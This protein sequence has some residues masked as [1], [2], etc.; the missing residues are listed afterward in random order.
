MYRPRAPRYTLLTLCLS[1][2]LAVAALLSPAGSGQVKETNF[3]QKIS[4]AL[5][6][7]DAL[8]LDPSGV[9]L[10][11][12]Q[13]GQLTLETS[14]GA[15]ALALAPNDI[16]SDDYRAVAV[17][18]GGETRELPRAPSRTFAGS[19]EGIE[20]SRA[21]FTIDGDTIEGLIIARGEKFFV[22]PA[23]HFADDA[24][25]GDF[26]FY[27]ESDV[28]GGNTLVCPVETLSAKVN[29]EAAR[30]SESS[31][32]TNAQAAAVPLSPKRQADIATEADFEF[33]QAN[34]SNEGAADNEILSIMN[35]VDGVYQAEVGITFKVVFQ[36]VWTTSA[37]PY[38]ATTLDALLRQFQTVWNTAPPAGSESR[39]LAHLWTGRDLDGLTAG[40][41][42]NDGTF[43]GVPVSGVVCRSQQF[44]YGVS[45]RQAI[46][47]Q[48]YIVPAHEIGH[49][50]SA[51]HPEEVQPPHVECA[52]TIMSGVVQSNTVFSFCQFSRDEITSYAN[53]NGSC[54]A[55]VA[56]D[57]P[58]IRFG[59]TDFRVTE[60]TGSV[61]IT[62]TR[63]NGTGVSSV[64]F[65]T[66]DG[67]ASER[68][69]YTTAVGTL[70]F[71]AGETT[72]SFNVFI[73][74]DAYGEGPETFQ[75][76]LSNQTGATL[77]TPSTAAVTIISNEALNGPNPVKDPTF[78][79]A[80]FV[81][82]HY[83][84]F[85]NR[86]PDAPG[87]SFWT[88]QTTACGNP[89]PLVCRVNVSAAF[90]LSI[91]FQE[92]GFFAIR[93]Q[94]AAFG[95]RS[96]NASTRMAYRELI[97]DQRQIGQGVVV[98][99]AGYEQLL[100]ANKNAYVARL[101]T[102]PDFA[103]RFPQ[104]TAD[105]YVDALFASAGVT[106]TPTERQNAI[107]AYNNAN[108]IAVAEKRTAALRSVAESASVTAAETRAAFVLLQYFGYLR[109]NPTD[110]PD[111]SDAGYQ[112]WLGKLNQFNGNFVAAQMVKA[113]ITSDEYQRRF[114]L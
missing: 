89:D 8:R 42:F 103:A 93:A 32:N 67:T 90:F 69:D 10:R 30:V 114:G 73:T 75:V 48:K 60:G 102:R 94:R 11:V 33:Y 96:D 16:R 41:A 111:T 87:L 99:Q 74:D 3:N 14:A 22:E 50:F 68:G 105:T 51:H 55:T 35:Q 37:D 5:A 63:S 97:R 34:G 31:A 76:L 72:K 17:L 56:A 54:L 19:V 92:T 21:R 61:Q 46:A 47:P 82:Q 25:P 70:T 108:L 79:P 83:V 107:N 43:N 4:R 62:V 101:V 110:A 88:G 28:I 13:T 38:D 66:Q 84:D 65:Q 20:G 9:E 81:R 80:F 26:L 44:S 12:R 49:N 7:Y 36:R 45:E 109:R 6:H 85:L 39:D 95:R 71:A 15:F 2:A 104:T 106:P 100:S 59:A 27:R 24:A 91:E 40:R 23:S 78:N 64:D 86:E 98:G 113:F 52:F 29:A 112:F 1:A 57:T 53:A 77:G 18:E 58:S